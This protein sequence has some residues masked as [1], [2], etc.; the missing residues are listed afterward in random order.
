MVLMIGGC[1][2]VS[3]LPKIL[4]RNQ[5][6]AIGLAWGGLTFKNALGEIGFGEEWEIFHFAWGGTLIFDPKL[7]FLH[8]IWK[9]LR[10]RRAELKSIIKLMTFSRTGLD[11]ISI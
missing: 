6:F 4:G 8:T 10:L 7:I 11:N 1:S 9:I 3:F 2:I 5:D